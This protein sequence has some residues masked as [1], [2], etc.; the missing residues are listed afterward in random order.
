MTNTRAVR[1]P[2]WRKVLVAVAL[3]GALA[4]ARSRPPRGSADL[5]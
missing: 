3:P 2:V 1:G 5:R 4:A